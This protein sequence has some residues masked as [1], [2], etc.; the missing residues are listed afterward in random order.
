MP[1]LRLTN[2]AILPQAAKAHTRPMGQLREPTQK[3]R[4][5]APLTME[6]VVLDEN[7]L[8][9]RTQWWLAKITELIPGKVGIA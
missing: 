5:A 3:H 4:K 2:L 9:K 6:D 8:K 7:N 1:T